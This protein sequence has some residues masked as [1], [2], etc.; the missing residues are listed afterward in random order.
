MH[1]SPSCPHYRPSES[2]TSTP[3]LP[4]PQTARCPSHPAGPRA[5]R[6]LKTSPA[7]LA[8][9]PAHQEGHPLD[10]LSVTLGR[11][12]VSRPQ[13]N[14]TA[15]HTIICFIPTKKQGRRLAGRCAGGEE[16]SG[17]RNGFTVS[18]SCLPSTD[19]GLIKHQL[20]GRT[21]SGLF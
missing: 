20:C 9:G 11:S 2:A 15:V 3:R 21:L 8:P 7:A 12:P 18:F 5:G 13:S 10:V 16:P 19:W 14:F 4:E 6:L 17:Y 1:R